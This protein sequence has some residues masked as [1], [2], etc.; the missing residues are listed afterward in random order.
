[1]VEREWK[2][3][4]EIVQS[5]NNNMKSMLKRKPLRTMEKSVAE[6]LGKGIRRGGRRGVVGLPAEESNK[7][8]KEGKE[9][10][11]VGRSLE[12]S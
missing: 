1:M 8:P 7:R 6:K 2:R 10:W 3:G 11:P 4:G 9:S 5:F 12:T